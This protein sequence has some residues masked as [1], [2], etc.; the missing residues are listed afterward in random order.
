[1]VASFFLA[2]IIFPSLNPNHAS[3]EY[4]SQQ[5]FLEIGILASFSGNM[6]SELGVQICYLEVWVSG[7]GLDVSVSN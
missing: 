4:S 5:F 2:N 6:D 7:H 3:N 1:M